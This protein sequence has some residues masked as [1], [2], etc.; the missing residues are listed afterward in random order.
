MYERS[1]VLFIFLHPFHTLHPV[2]AQWGCT[3]IFCRA[4]AAWLPLLF[5]SLLWQTISPIHANPP[6][7]RSCSC[8]GVK[9]VHCTFRHLTTIPETFPRDTERLNLGYNSLT[10][11]EG[12]E[13]R[14]LRQLEMLML[15]G[16]DISTL[17]QANIRE[18]R[19]FEGLVSLIRLHLD[20]N[21]IDFIE[22]YSFSGL[23]SLKLLQLEGNLLKEIHPQTFITVSILGSFWTSGLK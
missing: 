3:N 22:P 10:E 4:A 21:L 23:T 17:Q 7:P 12:S 19:L 5:S 2:M 20:H 6:C 1:L 13:F 16:N 14:S 15:H 9:E 8:P 18:P 11:V